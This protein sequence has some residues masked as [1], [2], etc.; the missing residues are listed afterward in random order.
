[1]NLHSVSQILSENDGSLPDIEFDFGEEKRSSG[2]YALVQRQASC[3]V[4]QGAYYWSKSKEIEVPIKFGENPAELLLSGE[5]EPFHVVFG[6][7]RSSSGAI[8]PD[9]GLFILG[10]TQ[11]SLDYRMGKKW[12]RG[13]I[14]GLFELMLNLKCLAPNTEIQ[15]VGNVFDENDI[16]LSAFEMW[17]TTNKTIR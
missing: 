10:S 4:S 3:L 14:E 1:M 11:I 12:N 8:I 15:H 16:L 7:M 5:A 2:A 17:Q 6:G 13:A 9:L